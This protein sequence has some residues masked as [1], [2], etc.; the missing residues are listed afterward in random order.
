MTGARLPRGADTVV[1]KENTQ[2]RGSRVIVS[3]GTACGANVRPAGED[4]RSGEVGVVRGEQ[5]TSARPGVLAS[6]GMAQVNVARR[7]RV[8]LLTTGDEL[9][10]PGK[11]LGFGQIHDSNRLSLGGLIEQNGGILLRHERVR[12]DLQSLRNALSRAGA[13][14]DL[15]VSSGGVSAGDADFLPGLIAEIGKV[16]FWKVRINRAPV[17]IYWSAKARAR[18]HAWQPVS[19]T[20]N[21][22]IWSAYYAGRVLRRRAF[23]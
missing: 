5:R 19:G 8:V 10:E 12:D 1:M 13:D 3:A 11:P 14:A 16:H 22:H 18:I 6:F 17:G 15:I 21:L 20:T 23:R 4:Y 9:V 2:T 7:P